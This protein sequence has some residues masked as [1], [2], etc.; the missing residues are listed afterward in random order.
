MFVELSARNSVEI[1][2]NEI[3]FNFDLELRTVT[4]TSNIF[5]FIKELDFVEKEQR[6]VFFKDHIEVHFLLM[7]NF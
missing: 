7:H 3:I 5:S 2:N 1:C 4:N 6:R